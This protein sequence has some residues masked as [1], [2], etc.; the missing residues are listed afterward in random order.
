MKNRSS[1]EVVLTPFP[2]R[3]TNLIL[4]DGREIIPPEE[5]T[6]VGVGVYHGR[7]EFPNS[8]LVFGSES[9]AEDLR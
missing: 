1:I 4:G 6:K 3:P 2:F 8:I 7:K 5:M 9:N